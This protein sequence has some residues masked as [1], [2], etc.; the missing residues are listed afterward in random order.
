MRCAVPSPCRLA[1]FEQLVLANLSHHNESRAN[2]EQVLTN[3]R[4]TQPAAF[5]QALMALLTA[6]DR[7]QPQARQFCA[8]ILRQNL[9]VNSSSKV[10]EACGKGVQA[11]IQAGLLHLF[12]SERDLGLRKKIT[13]CVAATASRIA[14]TD[15]IARMHR[16][17]ANT[18][19]ANAGNAT[20]AAKA[21]EPLP[22]DQQAKWEEL[23]PAVM[24]LAQQDAPDMR[25]SILDLIDKSAD[26]RTV[27]M[28]TRTLRRGNRWCAYYLFSRAFSHCPSPLCFLS[29]QAC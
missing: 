18:S 27:H 28:Q 26:R 15:V 3:L 1:E 7:G 8:V 22:E 21:L 10:W 25:F 17:A 6:G 13:D 2:A 9:L 12:T 23:L 16:L 24:A 19:N 4:Q 29:L 11:Q 5:V 20:A 14:G